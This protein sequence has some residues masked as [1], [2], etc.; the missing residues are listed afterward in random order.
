[1]WSAI[2]SFPQGFTDPPHHSAEDLA[3]GRLGVDNPACRHGRQCTG[4]IDHALAPRL[5]PP[6][7]NAALCAARLYFLSFKTLGT[8]NLTIFT[9]FCHCCPLQDPETDTDPRIIFKIMYP[10]SKA[11]SSSPTPFQI[12][13]PLLP[14]IL[15][16][17]LR[18]ALA[19][20]LIADPTVCRREGPALNRRKGQFAIAISKF[21]LAHG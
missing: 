9:G 10:F 11:T 21:N 14:A 20:V 7:Q 17:F 4:H 16:S 6:Q 19:A 13:P 15:H 1:M 12:P 8:A 2:A 18:N 5:L 3:P